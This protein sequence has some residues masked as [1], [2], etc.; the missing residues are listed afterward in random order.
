VNPNFLDRKNAVDRDDCVWAVAAPP[1]VEYLFGGG[2]VGRLLV[3]FG[4]FATYGHGR[5]S[6]P[7][8][9]VDR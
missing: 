6:P 8:S 4:R 3:M 7:R 2:L 5:R 1:R 9:L